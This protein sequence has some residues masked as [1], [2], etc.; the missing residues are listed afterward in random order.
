[1]N[2]NTTDIHLPLRVADLN[3]KYYGTEIVDAR[4]N[5]VC[6]IWYHTQFNPSEREEAIRLEHSET[7]VWGE[8]D[9]SRDDW[10][11]DSHHESQE[12]YALA[13]VFVDAANRM[14]IPF[15]IQPI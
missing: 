2:Q 3:G 15:E 4:N 13:K 11:N 10:Y 14:E 6:K 9:D 7:C 5:V 1:M 12:T 8:C